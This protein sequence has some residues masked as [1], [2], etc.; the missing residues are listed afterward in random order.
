MTAQCLDKRIWSR[1]ALTYVSIDD[2]E[3]NGSGQFVRLDKSFTKYPTRTNLLIEHNESNPKQ[4]ARH[5][6]RAREFE[7]VDKRQN[8]SELNL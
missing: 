2:L 3:Q 4:K 6:C 8:Q 1:G 5:L 7:S